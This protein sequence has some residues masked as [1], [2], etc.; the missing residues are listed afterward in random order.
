[1]IHLINDLDETGRPRGRLSSEKDE[2]NH[3][4]AAPRTRVIPVGGL[5]VLVRKPGATAARLPLEKRSLEARPTKDGLLVE[6]G[7]I[8]QHLMLVVE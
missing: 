3:P 6:V 2:V 8:E 7:C 4:M 1:V 5:Q